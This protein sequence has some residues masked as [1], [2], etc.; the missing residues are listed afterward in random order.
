MICIQ[1]ARS[2]FSLCKPHKLSTFLWIMCITSCITLFVL[3]FPLSHVDKFPRSFFPPGFFCLEFVHFAFFIFF[4]SFCSV[5]EQFFRFLFSSPL[6]NSV[7]TLHNLAFTLH[8][9]FILEACWNCRTFCHTNHALCASIFH[10]ASTQK[11]S[12]NVFFV[13]CCLSL[14][15][16]NAIRKYVLLQ[17][18]LCNM[19]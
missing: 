12:R 11:D 6:H 3:L 19:R 4:F 10:V 14:F 5:P 7:F 17:G 13:L 9:I 2:F 1:N 15:R 8:N 16:S 18:C